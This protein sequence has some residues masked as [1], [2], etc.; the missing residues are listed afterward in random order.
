MAG[1]ERDRAVNN[2]KRIA[3]EERSVNGSAE[4]FP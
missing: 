4:W 1:V 3:E 2:K